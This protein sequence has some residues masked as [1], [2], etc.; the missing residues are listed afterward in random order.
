MLRVVVCLLLGLGLIHAAVGS[1]VYSYSE[2]VSGPEWTDVRV[3][4]VNETAHVAFMNTI[5]P[6]P[7]KG[8]IDL[9]DFVPQPV[10]VTMTTMHS[11][12]HN[13]KNTVQNILYSVVIPT[14]IFLFISKEPYLLD[15]GIDVVPDELLCLAMAGFLNIVFVPNQGPHRKLLP[16]LKKYQKEDVYLVTVDDDASSD[17]MQ[18]LLFHL[19]HAHKANNY[20]EAVV[21]LRARRMTIC[22]N[23]PHKLYPYNQWPVMQSTTKLQMLVLPTGNPGIMYKPKYFHEAV[24]SPEFRNITATTDD[25]MFRLSAMMKNIPVLLG[26][27][28]VG[29][30][31][32]PNHPAVP[33][34]GLRSR[35]PASDHH[36]VVAPAVAV[37]RR[38]GEA[39]PLK[40]WTINAKGGNDAAWGVARTYLQTHGFNFSALAMAHKHEREKSWRV[41][42]G[43]HVC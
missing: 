26:C 9:T 1:S 39:P 21:A 33:A 29:N 35:L 19:L 5:L 7:V 38:L 43:Q 42:L 34:R 41:W 32:H 15:K 17:I 27:G 36:Q 10:Y 11:R 13:I 16:I 8:E 6:R 37:Q 22:K 25:L 2:I 14:K 30:L 4:V 23:A 40:L 28:S 12:V 20:P 31:C 18:G 24:F 3:R